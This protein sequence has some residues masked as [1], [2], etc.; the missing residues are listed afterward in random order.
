MQENTSINEDGIEILKTTSLGE[1]NRI[2]GEDIKKNQIMISRGSKINQQNINL[3]AES[4]I[5][6]IKVFKKIKI[7]FFTSGNE[8]RRPT[9]KLKNSEINNSNFFA[10]NSLLD[11]KFISKKDWGNLKDN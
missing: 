11:K 4:G 10:L 1:N 6:K 9:N 7:G 3:I 5:R 8:L 2:K